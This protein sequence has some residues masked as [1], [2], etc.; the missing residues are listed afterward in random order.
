MGLY[1]PLFAIEYPPLQV[2]VYLQV[3]GVDIFKVHVPFAGVIQLLHH[4]A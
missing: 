1:L 4:C 2:V 3:P